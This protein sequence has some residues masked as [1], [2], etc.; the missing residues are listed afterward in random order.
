VTAPP[1]P[2][3]S[4]IAIAPPA[5]VPAGDAPWFSLDSPLPGCSIRD[6]TDECPSAAAALSAQGRE[7]LCRSDQ[8][9]RRCA[10]PSVPPAANLLECVALADGRAAGSWQ[11]RRERC[12]RDCAAEIPRPIVLV[13][14]VECSQRPVYPCSSA[15]TEQSAADRAL[16]NI[17]ESCAAPPSTVLRLLLNEQG[18]ASGLSIENLPPTARCIGEAVTSWRFECAPP[19]ASTQEGTDTTLE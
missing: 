1:P 13:P 10:Y 6:L 15:G 7:I 8:I 11:I 9:G 4:P 2:P 12:R 14:G 19:C 5:P 17:L 16:A 18:C 3:F